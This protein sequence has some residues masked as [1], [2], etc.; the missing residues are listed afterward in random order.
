[1]SE[2]RVIASDGLIARRSGRWAK[3]KLDFLDRV[4][5]PALAA[6][7]SKLQR[8]YIDLFAGPGRNVDHRNREE[9][10]GSAL[11]ALAARSQA[12]PRV[13]FTHGWLVNLEQPDHDA[14]H[15]RVDRL[16]DE[17]KCP[18]AR[19]NVNH[20]SGDAN[21]VLPKILG[22][23]DAR[24]YAFVFADITKPGHWPWSTVEALKAQGHESVDAFILFPHM[25]GLNRMIPR[26]GDPLGEA[27]DRF[28]GC[29]DWRPI[30]ERH[31]DKPIRHRRHMRAEL[32]ELYIAR[33]KTHGFSRS[34]EA[35]NI[36]R[37]G[38]AELYKMIFATDSDIAERIAKWAAETKGRPGWD[39]QIELL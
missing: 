9:F 17:G 39:G 23:I 19:G 32:A 35:Q 37:R 18:T 33:L 26:D 21:I 38:S 27:L 12:D 6:T 31:A 1:M 22:R 15:A 10:T 14:L 13:Y 25:M 8:H 4:F 5:P 30:V 34:F 28:F 16:F 7:T 11:R 29:E 36:N 3:E 24:S 20:I 2:E